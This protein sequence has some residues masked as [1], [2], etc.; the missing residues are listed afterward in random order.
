MKMRSWT[1]CAV[2]LTVCLPATATGSVEAE[3]DA[4]IGIVLN[5]GRVKNL[6]AVRQ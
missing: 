2:L 1:L 4:V 5:A 6:Q 3:V